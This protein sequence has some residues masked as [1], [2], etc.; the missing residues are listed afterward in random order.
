[1]DGTRS[2]GW[3]WGRQWVAAHVAMYVSQTASVP[4]A[5]AGLVL[6]VLAFIF[7]FFS[8]RPCVHK[9]PTGCLPLGPGALGL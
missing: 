4:W 3:L 2:F 7:F 8:L 6:P 9:P 5:L 1:M